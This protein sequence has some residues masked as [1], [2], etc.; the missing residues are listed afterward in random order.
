MQNLGNGTLVINNGINLRDY[1]PNVEWDI[2]NLT[3]WRREK[4]YPCCPNKFPDMT[5]YITVRR[6]SLFYNVNLIVPCICIACLTVLVFYLPVN[7]GEKITLCI[8]ILLALTVFFLLLWE[9]TPTTSM[10]IPLMGKYLMFTM[11]ML[12]TSIFL[13]VLTTNTSFRGPVTSKM[14]PWV[15][16]FFIELLPSVLFIRRP[17]GDKLI[18]PPSCTGDLM[19][20][21]AEADVIG[22]TRPEVHTYENIVPRRPYIRPKMSQCE[23]PIQIVSSLAGIKAIS[24]KIMIGNHKK[25]VSYTC[26]ARHT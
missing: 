25:M 19:A 17:E 10:A 23:Y 12:T 13:T 11:S 8:S 24:H 20:H 5:F 3:V 4:L 26:K 15:R 14:H 1:Y 2:L 22:D 7:S 21:S 18:S 6:R 16:T 9:M